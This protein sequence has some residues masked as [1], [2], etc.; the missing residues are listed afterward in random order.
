MIGYL[1]ALEAAGA[2]VIDYNEFGD[3]QGT[4]MAYVEYN[5]KKGIVEDSYGSCSG[6]DSFQA[7]FDYIDEPYIRDGKY[8]KSWNEE[9]T[10]KEYYEILDAYNKRL[11]D[12][13]APYLTDL[14]QRD[15]YQNMIDNPSRWFDEDDLVMYQWAVSRFDA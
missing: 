8:Y 3:Y 11:A 7:E 4:W 2:V 5:G 10:K 9:I 14:G 12:F 13:G 1:I 15:Y 6:C